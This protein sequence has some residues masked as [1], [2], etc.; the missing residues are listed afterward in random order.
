MA[1]VGDKFVIEIGE[2]F[3]ATGT[4]M[5]YG[6]EENGYEENLYRIKGFNSLVFDDNGLNKLEKYEPPEE[7]EPS[8]VNVGDEVEDRS[9]GRWFV[10]FARRTTGGVHTVSGV[11]LDGRT[12]SMKTIEVKRTG[13]RNW[14]IVEALAWR[15]PVEML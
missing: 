8:P 6:C 5:A 3:K 12:H 11:G 1:K 7:E 13:R 2:V 4:Y 15:P 9:G 10:T 14:H